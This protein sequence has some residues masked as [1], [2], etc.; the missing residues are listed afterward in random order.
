[1]PHAKSMAVC[2]LNPQ[3]RYTKKTAI[4]RLRFKRIYSEKAGKMR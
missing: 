2:E 4:P 1:M 3:R